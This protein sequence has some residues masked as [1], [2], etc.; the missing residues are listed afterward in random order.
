MNH[1]NNDP[2]NKWFGKANMSRSYHVTKKSALARFSS[3]EKEAVVEFSEKTDIKKAQKSYRKI[4]GTIHP[5]AEPE[6][7]RNS[8]VVSAVK[9]AKKGLVHNYRRKEERTEPCASPNG[10]PAEPPGNSGVSGGLPSA[11]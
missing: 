10:G 3:G 7:L 6:G 11:S 9:A 4:Y 8:V 2:Y 1:T 5:A